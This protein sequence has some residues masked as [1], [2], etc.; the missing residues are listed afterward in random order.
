MAMFSWGIKLKEESDSHR[1]IRKSLR[2]R[3]GGGCEASVSTR[4]KHIPS[5]GDETDREGGD[6][7][8]GRGDASVKD[9]SDVGVTENEN[10]AECEGD[11]A[12]STMG[13]E[14]ELHYEV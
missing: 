12:P 3:V 10:E 14:P 4:T 7:F 2:C 6:G 5:E 9:V 13:A 8:C 11:T 1:L